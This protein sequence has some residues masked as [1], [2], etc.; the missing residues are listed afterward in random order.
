METLAEKPKATAAQDEAS[1]INIVKALYTD[2]FDSGNCP[3]VNNYYHDDAKCHFKGKVLSIESMKK[4]MA[5]FVARHDIT[6]TIESV[7]A[8]GDRTFARLRRD[9]KDKTSGESRSIEIMVE[10]RF[11]GLLVKELWFMV[12]DDIYSNTWLS[13]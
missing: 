3:V 7:V 12:D 5:S 4:S 1:M 9:V 8:K 13:N 10:K 11:E 6:T 2:V